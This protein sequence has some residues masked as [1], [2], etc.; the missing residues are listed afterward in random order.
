MRSPRWLPGLLALLAAAGCNAAEPIAPTAA[1]SSLKLSVAGD[2]QYLTGKVTVLLDAPAGSLS[3]VELDLRGK[4]VGVADAAPFKFDLDSTAFPDGAAE[5]T[6]KVVLAGSGATEATSLEVELANT[7]PKLTVTSPVDGSTVIGSPSRGFTIKPIVTAADGNAIARVWADTSNGALDLGKGDG[8]VPLTLEGIGTDFPHAAVKVKIHARDTSG[9]ETSVTIKLTPSNVNTRFEQDTAG[10]VAPVRS[11]DVL[12]DGRPLIGFAGSYYLL[13]TPSLT[14]KPSVVFDRV[15]ALV[16]SGQSLFFTTHDEASTKESLMLS[17]LTGKATSLFAISS[18]TQAMA[19]DPFLRTTGHVVTAWV[20]TVAF[21]SHVLSYGPDGKLDFDTV[22]PGAPIIDQIAETPDG[23]LITTASPDAAPPYVQPFDATSG[24][25]LPAWAPPGGQL[26]LVDGKGVVLL[27]Y[28]TKT[29]GT[30]A[31]HLASFDALGTPQWDELVDETYPQLVRRLPGG[32]VLVYLFGAGVGQPSSLTVIGKS[33]QTALWTGSLDTADYLLGEAPGSTDLLVSRFN[34]TTSTLSAMRL[35]AGGAVTWSSTLPGDSNATLQM[36][37]D[38]SVLVS[39]PDATAQTVTNAL[40]SPEGKTAWSAT[41]PGEKVLG[42]IEVDDLLILAASS[43]DM[44][45]FRFEA[46]NRATGA[47][48]WRYL[49]GPSREVFGRWVMARSK[50]WD[51]VFG[52][53]VKA[54]AGT[55]GMTYTTVTLGFVP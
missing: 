44:T 18:S 15:D 33:G 11:L 55:N 54:K 16:R 32:D 31:I 45:P 40:L 50:P 36:L 53:L 51:S 1:A 14:A 24:L 29:Y 43:G 5:L 27:Y 6:A 39:A 42:A 41:F 37:S 2:P 47:L 9:A 13:P 17:D 4:S 25:A 22:Y 8:S 19:F 34:S 38:G 46:M 12:D 28:T 35:G 49:E 52:S 20:D 3:H 21:T 7:A 48:S 23:R 26:V 30:P 10:A